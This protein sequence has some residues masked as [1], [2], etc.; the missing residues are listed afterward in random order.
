MKLVAKQFL[1]TF[2]FELKLKEGVDAF[3]ILLAV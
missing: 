1:K 3:V 2:L